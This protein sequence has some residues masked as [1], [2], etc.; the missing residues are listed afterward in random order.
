MKFASMAAP[1]PQAASPCWPAAAPQARARAWVRTRA[2]GRLGRALLGLA[3]CAGLRPA[4]AASLTSALLKAGDGS[5]PLAAAWAEAAH[6]SRD[7]GE[8]LA[9][10]Q[11]RSKVSTAAGARSRAGKVET[12]AEYNVHK[13][14]YRVEV[15]FDVQDMD[16]GHGLTVTFDKKKDRMV[17]SKGV[18]PVH[19][20]A[21]G[22]YDDR[23]DST[24]WSELYIETADSGLVTN[25]VRAYSAGFVEGVLT[26]VRISEFNANT[27]QL[28]LRKDASTHSLRHVLALLKKQL[29]HMKHMTKVDRET[30][31]EEPQDSYWKHV[32]YVLFQ[33]WGICDGYN[34]VARHY[35]R[36]ELDLLD[37]AVL[38]AAG[39]LPQLMEAYTQEARDGRAAAN[40]SFLQRGSSR[41]R[42][43][44]RGNASALT[45][46][47]QRKAEEDLRWERRVAGNGRCSALVRL[48]EANSDLLIGHTTW[49]DYSKMTRIFKY[50]KIVLEGADTFATQGA[51]SSYPGVVGSTDDFYLLDSGLG[52]MET[53]LIILDPKAWVSVQEFDIKPQIP[54]FAHIMA[55]N[56]LATSSAHWAQLF[57]TVNTGTYTSQWLVVDYNQFEVGKPLPDGTFWVI[58]AVPGAVHAEDMTA[59][60]RSRGYFPS[61]NRPYFEPIRQKSGHSAAEKAHGELYSW[62]DNPRAKI[63]AESAPA[64]NDPPTMRVLM[65]RNL[66][67]GGPG[68][69][70]TAG[71]EVSARMDLVPGVHLPNG[72]IDAKVVG[73]CLQRAFSVQAVSGPS[74]AALPAFQWALPGGGEAFPGWPHIGQPNSWKFDYVQMTPAGQGA[75]ADEDC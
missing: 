47:D 43:R 28:L 40:P 11:L 15:A 3:L 72:G 18:T 75:V 48:A 51:M 71:H 35:R 13:E 44:A 41:A 62:G 59:H 37:L 67:A 26:S 10:A 2:R 46:D 55:V 4:G 57:M 63:F 9:L 33:M 68:A 12:A 66:H 31:A 14:L 6:K 1:Q 45:L 21:W 60:L 39:E 58:E 38:N 49:D 61:F 30:M 69:L 22:H 34:K 32:R 56:R 25:D 53:S 23:I 64:V 5:A 19:G 24:G 20:L 29:K 16:A 52:V 42:A 54:N 70:D 17:L 27:R 36:R 50:Y 65:D 7:D 73:R 74:H 8:P